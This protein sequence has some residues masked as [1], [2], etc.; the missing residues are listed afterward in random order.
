MLKGSKEQQHGSAIH[1][2]GQKEKAGDGLKIERQHAPEMERFDPNE[3]RNAEG[4][5]GDIAVYED[6]DFLKL[7]HKT[8]AVDVIKG[9]AETATENKKIT[10]EEFHGGKGGLTNVPDGK[11]GYTEKA[12]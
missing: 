1:E 4:R 6:F 11:K 9:R 10:G 3:K 12:D 2:E 5:R 8:L 7:P